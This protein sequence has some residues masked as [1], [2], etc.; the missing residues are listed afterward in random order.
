MKVL[1]EATRKTVED[2]DFKAAMAKLST[3][4]NYMDAPDF[5]KFWERDTKRLADV[6]KAVGRIEEKK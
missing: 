1:R 5:Q 4:I 6:V 2:A 3:P